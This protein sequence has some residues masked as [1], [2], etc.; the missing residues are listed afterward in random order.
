MTV[1]KN[2]LTKFKTLSLLLC[3]AA[4]ET[5]LA[6]TATLDDVE[7]TSLP[8]NE[9]EITL[10]FSSPPPTPE[11]YS[12]EVPA[13]IVYD[14]PGVISQ[15]EEKKHDLSFENA[16]SAV[17]ITSGDRTRFILNLDQP[18]PFN[19]SLDGNRFVLSVGSTGSDRVARQEREQQARFAEPT[20]STTPPLGRA[21]EELDFSR[22]AEG[23]GL[24][25]MTLSDPKIS[26][27]VQ[28]TGSR[29]EL[30][31]F[32]TELPGELD[33]RLDVLDFATPVEAVDAFQDGTTTRV[34]IE[35]T[36]DY[37]FLVYQTDK[38]YVVSVKPLTE[39]ELEEKRAK[40]AFVGEKLSLNFQNI[41]V[42][43]V[44]QIIADFTDL[45]LVASDT[46]KG[47]ITL[48]LKNVPWDQALDIVLKAKGLDKRL[49][50][51]VLMVAPAAEIAE[52]ERLQ[53]EANKQ[54]QELAPLVT[55]FIRVK[56]ADAL[57][58][59]RLFDPNDDGPGGRE[60]ATRSL[61][62]SRGSASVDKRTNTII[63]TDTEDK[64]NEFRR[65]V[66]QIDIPVRQVEIAA[67]IVVASTDFTR[68]LG[69][70][71]GLQ[72]AVDLGGDNSLVVT[73]GLEG[74]EDPFNPGNSFPLDNP[75][76]GGG[77]GQLLV[78][79]DGLNVDLG[80]ANPAGQVTFGLLTEDFLLDLE[81]SALESDGLAEVASQPKVLTG[82]KQEAS[83]RS[84]QEIAYQA[85]GEDGADIEFKEA[86]LALKVTPQIT[87][88]DRVILD[89]AIS[90]DSLSGVAVN[91]QPVLDV[92][93]IETTALVGDGQTLVLGGIFQYSDAKTQ[94][95][96]P[97]LGDLPYIGKAFRRDFKQSEKR[98]ILIFITP[99]IVDDKLIDR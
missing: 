32:N 12:L 63:L 31:F 23:E 19:S 55:E 80:V 17:I 6:Q 26:V 62:S 94:E 82:D 39:R 44:L 86:V 64:I 99:K 81:L 96:V 74:L 65:L 13:R 24:I 54:L 40:F 59:Y 11:S 91:N 2:R 52:R 22:G 76:Y 30:S 98:E 3:F 37:D 41:A 78:G 85:V 88:D 38:Q 83:I 48:R 15:L 73:G 47:N 5:A 33:R 77:G 87:P 29:V 50:G 95:K 89:L 45:N 68:D 34:N 28:Q 93:S 9:F 61:L 53:V 18:A 60:T 58:L 4:M 21:I 56:Y 67:K 35:T 46:V 84:G 90:Q 43:S 79:G 66:D 51:N 49:E 75:V 20:V 14:F 42:R 7:F 69:V 71:W 72:S 1:L 36:G 10:E 97:V 57:A 25:T 16:Q 27:D 8:G 92:T 70:R